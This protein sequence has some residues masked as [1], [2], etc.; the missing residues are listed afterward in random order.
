M[1]NNKEKLID[2]LSKTKYIKSSKRSNTSSTS[3]D[4]PTKRDL[5][6]TSDVR[7]TKTL[8][9]NNLDGRIKDMLNNELA[10][11]DDNSSIGSIKMEDSA[12]Y[13]GV[14]GNSINDGG[15]YGELIKNDI[16]KNSI[17]KNNITKNNIT[18]NNITKQFGGEEVNPRN[19]KNS[20][21]KRK[22]FSNYLKV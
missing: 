4:I 1:I 17:T 22:F 6:P 11:S 20:I 12:N 15:K 14:F 19:R 10:L 21:D 8:S 2:S 18:K 3:S 7:N 13:D 5:S 9:G 16:T